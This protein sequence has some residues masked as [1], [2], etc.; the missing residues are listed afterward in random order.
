MPGIFEAFTETRLNDPVA[1]VD[2]TKYQQYH[3]ENCA[4]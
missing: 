2:V 1:E 3:G 4:K